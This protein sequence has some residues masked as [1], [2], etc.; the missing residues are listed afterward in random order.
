MPGLLADQMPRLAERRVASAIRSPPT[1]QRE[2]LASDL[3]PGNH[4]RLQ[5]A[6]T[7]GGNAEAD[8]KVG[9]PIF[10][11]AVVVE[12]EVPGT[13]AILIPPTRHRHPMTPQ[14]WERHPQRDSGL[15]VDQEVVATG[16]R[17]WL[18]GEAQATELGS[19]TPFR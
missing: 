5:L 18:N 7:P 6:V 12:V 1:V 14:P 4:E 15:P 10:Q 17:M 8:K 9:V 13:V 16:T 3:V 2:G 11:S 19:D